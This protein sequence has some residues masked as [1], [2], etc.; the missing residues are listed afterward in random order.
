MYSYTKVE[1]E[2]LSDAINL[3]LFERFLE[4]CSEFWQK[5][6]LSKAEHAHFCAQ[7]MKF[8]KDKT[9]ERVALYYR[10][11]Q[12]QDGTEV[13]NGIP[14]PTLSSLLLSIDWDNLADGLPGRFHGDFHFENIIWSS[15]QKMFTFLDWRQDFGDSLTIGD[16]YYDLAKLLHGMI[17]CHSLIA[18]DLYQVDWQYDSIDYD[19]HRKQILVECEQH[20]TDWLALQGYDVAK[21]KILT[22]LIFLN[23]AALH[24]APYSHLLYALGKFLIYR[25][26]NNKKPNI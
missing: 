21:V 4:H 14:M 1:G 20:F 25:S 2:V 7:C 18:K 26:I 9:F 10:N 23:I 11:F 22:A 13:I 3:P 6:T 24:H 19:F 12:T 5:K 15:E 16:I 17:I 8:Y